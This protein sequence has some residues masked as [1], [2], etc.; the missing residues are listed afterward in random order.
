MAYRPEETRAL[1]PHHHTNQTNQANVIWL[2][3]TCLREMLRE[4]ERGY[5]IEELSVS[6]HRVS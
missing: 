1:R 2:L 4:R 5:R 6:M 3:A